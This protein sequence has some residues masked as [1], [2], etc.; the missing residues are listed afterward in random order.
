VQVK[1]ENYKA[2]RQME[3][4]LTSLLNSGWKIVAQSG[5]FSGNPLMRG[6]WAPKVT[7]TL[8]QN[9]EAQGVA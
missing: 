2:R 1:V 9:S 7:V 8:T 6:S 3:K 4:G 5:A